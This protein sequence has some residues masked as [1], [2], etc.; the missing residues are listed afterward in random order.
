MKNEKKEEMVITIER[1]DLFEI[2]NSLTWALSLLV[3]YV[4]DWSPSM[5]AVK[6]LLTNIAFVIAMI[7]LAKNLVCKN[8]TTLYCIFAAGRVVVSIALL[9][10]M[11]QLTAETKELLR[12]ILEMQAAQSQATI[13]SFK[14]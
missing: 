8:R 2:V 10:L 9:I 1:D 6:L 12:N 3:A 4:L 11:W 5:L 7:G 14:A 13:H